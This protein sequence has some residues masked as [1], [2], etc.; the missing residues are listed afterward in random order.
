MKTV[1]KAE[2]LKLSQLL[3]TFVQEAA[4]M[5]ARYPAIAPKDLTREQQPIQDT[6]EEGIAQYF[7]YE[8]LVLCNGVCTCNSSAKQYIASLSATPAA[9]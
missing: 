2:G 5:S 9:D 1:R 8:P 3:T 7:K 6:L 4:V